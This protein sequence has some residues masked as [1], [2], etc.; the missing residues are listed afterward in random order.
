[1]LDSTPKTIATGVTSLS[2]ISSRAPGAEPVASPS[3]RNRPMVELT[4]NGFSL[5][6]ALLE[7]LGQVG[8]IA[9]GEPDNEVSIPLR[10]RTAL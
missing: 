7:D 4:D 10:P 5:P 6:K 8:E 3:I 9:W 2:A 1:M